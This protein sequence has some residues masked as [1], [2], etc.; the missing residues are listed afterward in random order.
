MEVNASAQATDL[1]GEEPLT[2]C[3]VLLTPKARSLAKN[4]ASEAKPAS[5]LIKKA[6]PPKKK[7]KIDLPPKKDLRSGSVVTKLGQL[8][9]FL[10]LA[11]ALERVL[12]A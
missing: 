1:A 3:R 6:L 11:T 4:K 10:V 8:Q 7:P 2:R 9:A 5:Q 12:M